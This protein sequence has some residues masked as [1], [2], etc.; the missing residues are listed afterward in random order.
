MQDRVSESKKNH[1]EGYRRPPASCAAAQ[2]SAR[3]AP[4]PPPHRVAMPRSPSIPAHA[5]SHFVFLNSSIL[6]P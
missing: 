4:P 2:R 3:M 5:L 1:G 6:P